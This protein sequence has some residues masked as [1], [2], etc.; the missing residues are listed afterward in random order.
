MAQK[1]DISN[2][3]MTLAPDKDALHQQSKLNQ[4]YSD[5]VSSLLKRN[6]TVCCAVFVAMNEPDGKPNL[7]I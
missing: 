1:E 4:S 7:A 3:P 5:C 6:L 2:N